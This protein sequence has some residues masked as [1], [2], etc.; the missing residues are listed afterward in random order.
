MQ[1]HFAFLDWWLFLCEVLSSDHGFEP[2]SV[3]LRGFG[4]ILDI[5]GVLF[6]D[7]VLGQEVFHVFVASQL[8]VTDLFLWPAVHGDGS[9]ETHFDAEWAV[10]ARTFHADDYPVIHWDPRA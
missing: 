7:A 10:H 4:L 3:V 9:N 6:S 8:H 5:L 2:I 1:K